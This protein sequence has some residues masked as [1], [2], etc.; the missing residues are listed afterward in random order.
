[1]QVGVGPGCL[2][3]PFAFAKAGLAPSTILLCIMP[4]AVVCV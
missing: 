4:G 3:L 2:A 1:M